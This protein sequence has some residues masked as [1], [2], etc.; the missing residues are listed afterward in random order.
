MRALITA[1]VAL[2]LATSPSALG[3][4]P[5]FVIQGDFRIGGYAVKRDGSLRGMIAAFDQPSTVRRGT[6]YRE[7]C[8]VAWRP[9]GLRVTLYNLG[10]S[11]PCLPATGHFSEALMATRIWRTS[12]GLRIGDSLARLRAL[13]RN[14][15]RHGA[16]W[17]LITR[18][19]PYGAGGSYPGLAAK[20]GRGRVVAFAVR[21]PAG[22]H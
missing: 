16:W 6:R 4:Q 5:S 15:S 2:A 18:R 12:M 14:E 19:S 10:G 17:W 21:Y 11:N 22:G 8:Y 1:A 9:I 3:H 20:V 7:I 13:Y